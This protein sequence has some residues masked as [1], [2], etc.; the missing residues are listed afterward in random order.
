[1]EERIERQY[2]YVWKD[3]ERT[4]RGNRD[5]KEEEGLGTDRLIKWNGD[6]ERSY[7]VTGGWSGKKWGGTKLLTSRVS[8]PS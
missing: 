4:D 3:E 6:Y 1:M 2:T 7:L 8:S 5:M